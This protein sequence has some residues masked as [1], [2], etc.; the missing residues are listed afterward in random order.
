MR[1]GIR[2]RIAKLTLAARQLKQASRHRATPFC[3]AFLTDRQRAPHPELIIR[4]L[5]HDSI[6]IFR[7]YDVPR[8]AS[9]ARRLKSLCTSRGIAF[10]VGADVGLAQAVEADGIHLP[11]WFTGSHDKYC[12]MTT[13]SCH[14]DA[15]IKR[16]K[17][18]GANMVFISPAFLTESHLNGRALGLSTFHALAN[19]SGLPAFALGGVDENNAQHLSAPN[20]L[21]FG[22]IGAFFPKA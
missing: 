22:A 4:L 20:V 7:D 19:S 13:M 21:G 5:P 14:H 16:A 10:L 18:V 3:L 12:G 2:T 6:V 17:A 9:L 15:D 1:D 11:S 8:R